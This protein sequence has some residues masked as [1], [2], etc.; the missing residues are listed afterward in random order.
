LAARVPGGVP[1]DFEP[2]ARRY[3]AEVERWTRLGRLTGYGAGADRIR[4]LI[5]GSLLFLCGAAD[6]NAPLADV[7]SGPGVPGLILKLARPDWSI[8]L[9]EARRR[10]ANFLRQVL[11]ALELRGVEV[12][13]G[14]VEAPEIAG[15][16]R[17]RFRGVTLRAVARPEDAIRLARPLMAPGGLAIIALGAER[18]APK[19][20][21][22]IREVEG[23]PLLGRRRFLIVAAD[24][25]RR[26]ATEGVSRGT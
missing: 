7:G 25:E 19:A 24:P 10:P 12:V 3:L 1:D 16:L 17:G 2:Q 20:S 21:G 5:G 8:T 22:I 9:V 23:S 6:L 13:E 26:A 14:R 15:R 4:E 11:R 18:G